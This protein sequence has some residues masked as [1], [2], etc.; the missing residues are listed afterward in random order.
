MPLK[1]NAIPRYIKDVRKFI[2]STI[3]T[4]DR[5]LV[6]LTAYEDAALINAHR[7]LERTRKVLLKVNSI[8]DLFL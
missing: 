2:V 6:V 1:A 8:L 4:I 5:S 7:E 3:S